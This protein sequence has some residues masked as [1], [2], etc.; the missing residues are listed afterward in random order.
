[1]AK[2]FWPTAYF[3]FCVPAEIATK[4]H[5]LCDQDFPYAGV[6]G[7][8]KDLWPGDVTAYSPYSVAVYRR[9]RKLL[10]DKLSLLQL[11]RMAKAQSGTLCHLALESVREVAAK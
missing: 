3:Y 2:P 8:S 7:V 11:A 5:L 1:M 4:V 9:A 6:L 10:G